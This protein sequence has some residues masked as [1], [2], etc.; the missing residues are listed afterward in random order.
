VEAIIRIET[1]YIEVKCFSLS[2]LNTV[3]AETDIKNIR[4]GIWREKDTRRIL[5]DPCLSQILDRDGTL[6]HD[7]SFLNTQ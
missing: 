6:R 7:V 5:H 2:G 3:V 4:E 1:S